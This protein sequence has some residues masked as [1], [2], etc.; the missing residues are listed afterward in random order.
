MADWIVAESL[1]HLL[2]QL[3]ALA[4]NRSKA[5]DGGIGDAKHATRDSD[6]NPW[7]VLS[8]QPLV[9]ARDFTHD[10]AGGL[11]CTRLRDSLIRARDGRV[12][13]II[14]NQQIISGAGGPQPWVR[15]RYY[16]TNPHT[17]HLHLSVVAD[18]R[19]RSV[20]PWSLPGLTSPVMPAKYPT[21]QRGSTG[22][23]VKLIQRFLGV[24][25]AGAV[26]YGYFGP[27]TET[28]V[29]RYQ[30]MRG[31]TPDGVVGPR[32]WAETGL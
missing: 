2:Q 7:L 17:K 8:G 21:L 23:A 22:E 16:G 12:K 11:D 30:A 13:Y 9:T 1:D 31:L 25:K 24:V 10:P 19:C 32:T 14:Y 18:R 4:P 20:S 28:A 15:R 3:N 27:L 29:K 5:S 6:H 26:G